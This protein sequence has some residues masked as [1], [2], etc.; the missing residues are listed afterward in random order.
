MTRKNKKDDATLCENYCTWYKPGRSEELQ[1]QGFIVVHRLIERGRT[2]GL[3][4]HRGRPH[5]LAPVDA[6]KETLCRACSFRESDC[7]FIGR[8]GALPCGGFVLLSH[9]LDEGEITLEDIKQES[10]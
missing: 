7:D 5:A 6:L 4:K 1:C 2:I 3:E 10:E 8:G 9:L